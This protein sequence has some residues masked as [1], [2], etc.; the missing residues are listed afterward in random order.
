MGMRV[1]RKVLAA[2]LASELRNKNAI[3]RGLRRQGAS[4]RSA[5]QV[6]NRKFT[7]EPSASTP[8]MFGNIT[9]LSSCRSPRRKY[10]HRYSPSTRRASRKATSTSPSRSAASS[11]IEHTD[12]K[13]NRALRAEQGRD[14]Q[15]LDGRL[16]AQLHRRLAAARLDQQVLGPAPKVSVNP[17][18]SKSSTNGTPQAQPQSPTLYCAANFATTGVLAGG[19]HLGDEFSEDSVF[20]DDAESSTSYSSRKGS[21]SYDSA[22]SDTTHTLSQSSSLKRLLGGDDDGD[23]DVVRA[24]PAHYHGKA[25]RNSMPQAIRPPTLSMSPQGSHDYADTHVFVET[26]PSQT[27]T[28]AQSGG[29][30][31]HADPL[32]PEEKTQV[33][34]FEES[35][36]SRG[37]DEYT[38]I[39]TSARSR[40]SKSELVGHEEALSRSSDE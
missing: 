36:V 4:K 27:P 13:L 29:Q 11:S 1:V 20:D 22:R 33:F 39:S 34:T 17:R 12:D 9:P 8:A 16:A 40:L 7:F 38:E 30:Q 25:K 24:P 21:T 19:D 31:E 26:S 14:G 15:D 23:D 28:L 32:S 37:Q 10:L 3:I 35:F 18:P 2:E 6:S 5:R